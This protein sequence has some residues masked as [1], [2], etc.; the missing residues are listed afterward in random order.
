MN[1]P[2]RQYFRRPALFISLPSKGQHYPAGAIEVPENG[3]FPVYPMTA[4][5]EI[6]AKTPD[7]LFNGSAVAEIIRSCVPAI[8]DPWS[9]PATDLDAILIG[10]RA[11]STGSEMDIESVC[12]ACEE[13]SKYG[14][15]LVGLLNDIKGDAYLETLKLGELVFHFKPLSYREV[16]Q[17]N[18]GQFELQREIAQLESIEDDVE[19]TKKSNETMKKLT[20]MNI[21]FMANTIS[22]ID[23]PN[24]SVTENE[25]IVEYLHG[26]DRASYDAIRTQIVKMRESVNIKPLKIKCVA[27]NN[28][29]NQPLALNVTD[30]FV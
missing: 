1:N 28:E 27:C 5:D 13:V 11:A 25:F 9:I 8:K 23:L 2:L 18:L 12:P 16:N 10:I 3:E 20:E 24:E 6:T 21:G 22:K 29:Y 17:G 14:V 4:I 19:R 15:N 7:A 30:F 26:C